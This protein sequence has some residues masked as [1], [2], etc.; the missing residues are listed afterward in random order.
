MSR[1]LTALMTEVKNHL[2]P[3][4]DIHPSFNDELRMNAEAIV[5]PGYLADFVASSAVIDYKNKQ[6]VLEAIQPKSRLEKLLVCLEEEI[7]LL[8]CIR[9]GSRWQAQHLRPRF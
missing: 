7:M 2:K 4:K 9:E 3:L 6:I 5:D 1:E 8:E